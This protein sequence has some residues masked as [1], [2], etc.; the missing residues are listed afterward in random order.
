MFLNRNRT[1]NLVAKQTMTWKKLRVSTVVSVKLRSFVSN[2]RLFV[3]WNVLRVVIRNFFK[4]S[5]KFHLF[6]SCPS[7]YNCGRLGFRNGIGS[8]VTYIWRMARELAVLDGWLHYMLLRNKVLSGVVHDNHMLRGVLNMT[9]VSLNQ[10]HIRLN[11]RSTVH[12]LYCWLRNW[13]VLQRSMKILLLHH[14]NKLNSLIWLNWKNGIV[15]LMS[16][17]HNIIIWNKKLWI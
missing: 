17:F 16:V 14:R 3:N 15:G 6:L 9:W 11:L 7:C 10:L 1:C 2:R 4:S 12:S 13:I 8:R 5:V